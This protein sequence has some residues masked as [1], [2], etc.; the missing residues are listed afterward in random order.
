MLSSG[1]LDSHNTSNECEVFFKLVLERLICLAKPKIKQALLQISGASFDDS[2]RHKKNMPTSIRGQKGM[3]NERGEL[4]SSPRS[5]L[6]MIIR[7]NVMFHFAAPKEEVSIVSPNLIPKRSV[8][9]WL[10]PSTELPF[11]FVKNVPVNRR[12]RERV[13][14]RVTSFRATPGMP[15]G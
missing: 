3:D 7:R 2:Q 8:I 5:L 10:T 6:L 13:R 14:E 1:R 12:K 9:A 15:E 11:F 4:P